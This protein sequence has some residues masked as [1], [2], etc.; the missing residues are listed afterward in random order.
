MRALRGYR[1]RGGHTLA[2]VEAGTSIGIRSISLFENDALRLERIRFSTLLVLLDYYGVPLNMFL[3]HAATG[4]L[5]D[6]I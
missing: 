2:E 4:A 1:E 3:V 6:A 5:D